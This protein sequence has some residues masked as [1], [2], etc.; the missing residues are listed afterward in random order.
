MTNRNAGMLERRPGV[1]ILAAIATVLGV[2]AGGTAIAGPGRSASASQEPT[3]RSEVVVRKTIDLERTSE[4][5][6]T[7]GATVTFAGTTPKKLVGTKVKLQRR[8]PASKKWVAVDTSKVT[9]D[10][11]FNVEGRASGAG[12]N[13]WRAVTPVVEGKRQSSNKSKSLVFAWFYLHDIDMVDSRRFEGDEA[14][15]AGTYYAKSAMNSSNFW[16]EDQP[17]GEWNLGYKCKTFRATIGLDDG[18]P[19]G[20]SVAFVNVVD[21]VE[22]NWGT[23]GNGASQSVE[24]DITSMFRLRLED[25]YVTGPTG[26]GPATILGVWG[27]AQILCSAMPA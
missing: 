5:G 7:A 6:T 16:W 14:T 17:W 9:R 23:L 26:S 12:I 21:D 24:L 4:R 1:T 2:A 22:T 20:S 11:T 19:S 25:H 15:V 3:A 8:S 27:N 18:S 13:T 10:K